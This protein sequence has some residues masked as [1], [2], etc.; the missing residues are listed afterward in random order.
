MRSC[1]V[2][3]RMLD[4]ESREGERAAVWKCPLLDWH[5]LEVVSLSFQQPC[6]EVVDISILLQSPRCTS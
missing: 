2:T 3:E 5:L 4:V 6:G 1:L